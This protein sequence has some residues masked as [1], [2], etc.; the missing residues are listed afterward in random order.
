MCVRH[1]T[2]YV[3]KGERERINHKMSCDP[4]SKLTWANSFKNVPPKP[5]AAPGNFLEMQIHS[6]HPTLDLLNQKLK[7]WTPAN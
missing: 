7:G 5:E 6:P 4:E 1:D 3:E 2:N